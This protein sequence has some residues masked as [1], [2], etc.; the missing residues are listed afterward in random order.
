MAVES[1]VVLAHLEPCL[2]SSTVKA[3]LNT[4]A[5]AWQDHTSALNLAVTPCPFIRTEKSELVKA[6]LVP[7]LL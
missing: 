5:T 6:P 7:T 1:G 3:A 4:V 2:F